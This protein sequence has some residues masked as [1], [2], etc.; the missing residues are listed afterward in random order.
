M[1]R[2]RKWAI[3]ILLCIVA[4]LLAIWVGVAKDEKDGD[5][6]SLYENEDYGIGFR[7]PQGYTE[8]PFYI[9]DMETDGNGLMVEFFAPEADMQI[10]S[11][12]YLDKAYWENEVKESYSGMYRQVYADEERGAALRFCDGCAV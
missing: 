7:M 10:F 9:S 4:V 1:Q 12:W 5:R 8:N 3:G 2:Q 11:F 6:E